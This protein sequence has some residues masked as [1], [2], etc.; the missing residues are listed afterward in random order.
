[1]SIC[2]LINVHFL[3][4]ATLPPSPPHHHHL[5][6]PQPQAASDYAS[7][8]FMRALEAISSLSSRG[9]LRM[10]ETEPWVGVKSEDPAVVAKAHAVLVEV[11]EG[12]R[13]WWEALHKWVNTAHPTHP[14]HPTPLTPSPVRGGHPHRG[15]PPLPRHALPLP[16]HLRPAGVCPG[17]V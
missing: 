7:L 4:L 17:G 16:P 8:R 13:E 1:M 3:P 12:A 6:S 2:F 10:Q 9:N 11:R 15:R 14:P 5:S